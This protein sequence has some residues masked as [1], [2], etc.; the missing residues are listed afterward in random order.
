MCG[1]VVQ[2]ET[3]RSDVVPG[4]DTFV[5]KIGSQ[6]DSDFIANNTGKGKQYPM[7]PT[8]MFKGVEVPCMVACTTNG[9]I[10]SDILVQFLKIR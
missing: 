4:I 5:E 2:G 3:V 6:D 1:V 9:S 8:C 10:T 7:G